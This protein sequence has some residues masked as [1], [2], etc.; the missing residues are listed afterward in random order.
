MS[1][2][3]MKMK[4]SVKNISSCEVKLS[5]DV[6]TEV[7]SDE[8]AQFYDS[9]RKRA[10]I[11]GFRPGH[12]PQNVVALHYKD[13]ARREV[14]Q[15][16]LSRSIQHAV[17]QEKI[18]IIGYPRVEKVDF[19]EAHLKFDALIEMKPKIKIDKY[20]GL[21]LKRE[22]ALVKDA[23]VEESIKQLQESKAKYVAVED[24][25][26]RMD[27]FLICD[28]TLQVDAQEVEKRDGEWIQVRE[29]DFL[30]GFSKQLIGACVGTV[31]K[32]VVT[33]PKDYARKEWAGKKGEFSVTIKELKEKKLPRLDDEFVKEIGAQESLQGLRD[34]VRRD[35]ETEKNGQIDRKLEQAMLDELIRKSKFD[36][37]S[38]IVKRR[39]EALVDE[40]VQGLMYRGAKEEEAEKER[41]NLK[42]SLQSEAERDVRISFLLAEI[43]SRE[44]IKGTDLDLEAKFQA[45]A[46]RFR[47]PIAEVKGYY[48]Q[49]ENR[50]ESLRAQVDQEKTIQWIKD[51]AKI[52]ESA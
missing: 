16:L 47:R 13:E 15:Q 45:V 2:W 18:P 32:V 6:P 46:D 3:N 23:E 10:K 9:V 26:V 12:A 14:L 43:A 35:L 33:F 39:L 5:I 28:Y 36:V 4:L 34:T 51:R 29:K 40:A 8:F 22:Q 27:D 20:V 52:K 11:P 30:A 25:E 19:G 49:D 31:Q 24:R 17:K 44:E 48:G 42:K 1:N 38:G 7:V 41:E 21:A 37:P 50:L